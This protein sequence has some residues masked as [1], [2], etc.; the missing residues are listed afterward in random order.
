M[1]P[2]AGD[3]L[4]VLPEYVKHAVD[5]AFYGVV[6]SAT[7]SSVRVESVTSAAPGTY[8]VA[9]ATTSG[10]RVPHSEA[11][12]SQPGV[13]LRKAV[14]VRS[15]SFH[16][17]GQVHGVPALVSPKVA[18][19][20][21]EEAHDQLLEAVLEGESG[22]PL[23][24]SN[25][26]VTVP[27]LKD[28]TNYCV[29]WLVPASGAVRTTSLDHVLWFVYYVDGK[30]N[31]PPFSFLQYQLG[32]PFCEEPSPA[33]ANGMTSDSADTFFEPWGND[34][35]AFPDEERIDLA[36]PPELAAETRAGNGSAPET[37]RCNPQPES[38]LQSN[39]REGAITEA[40]DG[41]SAARID[42]EVIELLQQH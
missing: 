1:A 2:A 39:R 25:R 24:S 5:N 4:L 30:R 34:D 26:S 6:V 23:P 28:R 7:G 16:Y 18:F 37:Q 12:G 33:A 38:W 36:A 19:E 40:T 41:P 20:A 14:C 22:K 32:E 11:E 9:K 31:I 21:L 15:G 42:L 17:Y 29:E 27:D 10:R 13:W 35:G 8:S 3:F